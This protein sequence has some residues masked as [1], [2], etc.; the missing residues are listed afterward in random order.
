SQNFQGFSP[1]AQALNVA[2][3]HL[4]RQLPSQSHFGG[5]IILITRGAPTCGAD[6]MQ[7]ED[8]AHYDPSAL[9]VVAS[10]VDLNIRTAVVAVDPQGAP[11]PDGLD[12]RLFLEQLADNGGS[13]N[14]GP[15]PYW[16]MDLK[17]LVNYFLFA[18]WT[19]PSCLIETFRLE[20]MPGSKWA[21]PQGSELHLNIAGKHYE[22]P[23]PFEEACAFGDGYLCSDTECNVLRLCGKA[24]DTWRE[25]AKITVQVLCPHESS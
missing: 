21:Y 25:G 24:C 19:P 12:R 6:A 5:S 17:D 15:T 4:H 13:M 3:G 22:Q 20:N 23:L 9:S 10:A 7:P 2:V 16:D 1:L 14:I 8:F 11:G 18:H